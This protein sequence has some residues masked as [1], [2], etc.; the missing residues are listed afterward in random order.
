[1]LMKG[2]CEKFKEETN[3]GDKHISKIIKEM[4]DGYYS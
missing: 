2:A 4:A 3:A 1:M